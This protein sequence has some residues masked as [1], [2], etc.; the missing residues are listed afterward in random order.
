MF[1]GSRVEVGAGTLYVAPLGT[2]EPTAVTGAWPANWVALGYTDTGST[3]SLQP[4][5]QEVTVEEEYWPV[6]EMITGYKGDLTFSLA[7]TTA[8]NLLVA[9]NDGI[10]SGLN[11]A[12]TGTNPDGSVWV[13]PPDIGLESRV[14]LGWDSLPKGATAGNSFARLIARQCLQT[15]A[16]KIDRAKGSKKAMYTCTFSLEKPT[17]GLQPVRMIFPA[18][19]AA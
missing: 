3:F 1:S 19:L 8:Q 11:A 10:G 4:S 13:E 6:R 14:M 17:T 16:V 5:V 7:E 9:F 12:A 15:G 2:V 18:A